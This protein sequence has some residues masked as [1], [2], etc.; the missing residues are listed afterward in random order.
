MNLV[1]SDDARGFRQGEE[2]M[3]VDTKV[4]STRQNQSTEEIDGSSFVCCPL[5]AIGMIP[6]E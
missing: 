2:R 1:I 5:K 3:I 4:R 6:V